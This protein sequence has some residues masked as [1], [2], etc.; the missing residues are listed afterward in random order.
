MEK[1]C[2]TMCET[3]KESSVECENSS[4]GKDV[5]AQPMVQV[6]EYMEYAWHGS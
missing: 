2:A 4:W 3:P 6:S 1:S 5:K